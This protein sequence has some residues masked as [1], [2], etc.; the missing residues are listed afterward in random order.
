MHPFTHQYF[1]A[2]FDCFTARPDA[3]SEFPFADAPLL[4]L[5]VGSRTDAPVVIHEPS[6][7]PHHRS[8]DTN[9]DQT[10]RGAIQ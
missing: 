2:L 4:K 8:V 3:H 1:F 9:A 5:R 6:F 10:I 7:V